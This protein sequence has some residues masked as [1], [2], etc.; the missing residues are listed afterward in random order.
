MKRLLLLALLT[1]GLHANAAHFDQ[2]DWEVAR[3]ASTNA[4]PATNAYSGLGY[5]GAVLWMKSVRNAGLRGLV[6]RANLVSGNGVRGT[7]T[8]AGSPMSPV[9]FDFGLAGNDVS[10]STF[11]YSEGNGL[12]NASIVTGFNPTNFTAN[13]ASIA[14]YLGGTAFAEAEIVMGCSMAAGD[15]FLTTSYT[16]LGQTAD[17]WTSTG[18][19]TVAD[20]DGRG[21]YVGS[22]TSS[23][24]T[25]VA[26]YRNGVLTG[27]S[28]SVGGS[29]PN[30]ATANA[31]GLLVMAFNTDGGLVGQSRKALRGYQFT[32]GLSAAQQETFNKFWDRYNGPS[33]MNRRWDK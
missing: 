27:T 12:T 5:N 11:A 15:C 20:T 19:P 28:S 33:M 3:W 7:P 22:R 18:R 13:D 21:F 26:I 6:L 17:I 30:T 31:N 1:A 32:R 8:S 24:A 14:I 4:T 9:V 23:A 29:P 16:A 2:Y 10:L 25:G